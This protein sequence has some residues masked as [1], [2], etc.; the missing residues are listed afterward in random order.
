[1]KNEAAFRSYNKQRIDF[2]RSCL[3]GEKCDVFDLIAFLIHEDHPKLL[4]NFQKTKPL[5]GI[6]RFSY[7]QRIKS[8]VPKY[9]P[10]FLSFD[11][12]KD[13]CAV[14]FLAI[15]G[16]AGTAA[17][18][19]ESDLDFWVGVETEKHTPIELEFFREKLSIIEKW[20]ATVA[21]LEVHFFLVDPKKIRTDDYGAITKE[22]CG[23]ALGN[24]LKDEFYRTGILIT[25]KL[26]YFWI[27][28]A[29]TTVADYRESVGAAQM[30]GGEES[31]PYIDLGYI[32]AI[33]QSEYFGAALWQILKGLHSPFKSALKMALLDLYSS[34]HAQPL[35]CDRFKKEI[36]ISAAS[37]MPDPYLFL[38]ESLLA[39][40]RGP[41]V[42]PVKRLLEKCF[43]IRNLVS[44]GSAGIQGQR[45]LRRLEAIASGWD[46][47]EKDLQ[48]LMA[49]GSWDH[50]RQERFRK[51]IIDFLMNSYKR[52]RDRTKNIPIHISASDLSAVGKKIQSFF[53]QAPG[54][55]PFEFSL[56]DGKRVSSIGIEE[57]AG[58]EKQWNVA[59]TVGSEHKPLVRIMRRMSHPLQ[60]CG[61]CSINGF[62]DGKPKIILKRGA[63]VS[64]KNL[65]EIMQSVRDFFPSSQSDDSPLDV[66]LKEPV[67]SHLLI[68]PNWENPD[69]T[70]TLT[71]ISALYRTSMGEVF[72]A[73]QA[74]VSCESWLCRE[75]LSN[76]VGRQNWS[77]L[78]WKVLVSKGAIH[79]TR[80]LSDAVSRMTQRYISKEAEKTD[81][82]FF[83]GNF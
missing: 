17:F 68:I 30:K 54:K 71:S 15:I 18:S 59:V 76:A 10:Y 66:L 67:V 70:K 60:V 16:S 78:S 29:E 36:F 13:D 44:V 35:L 79:S 41:H 2:L 27:M 82:F 63:R 57:A 5:S 12:K 42:L 51:E 6:S 21:G 52:I 43:L 38:M 40:Y 1:M 81:L 22:S 19:E 49:F 48:Y 83:R 14:A 47:S 50:E 4:G 28:P 74:G 80:R 24:L 56:F 25:G 33:S 73:S 34:D 23:T 20:A 64:E 75:I 39:F 69:W 32:Q 8:V 26:P 3:T 45:H 72:Y 62:Y 55:I 77:R 46:W 37:A 9:F 53:N 11:R 7:T 58:A 31:E 61:W 65:R